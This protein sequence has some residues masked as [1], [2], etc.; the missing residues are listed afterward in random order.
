MKVVVLGGDGML[1]HQVAQRLSQSCEVVA[2]I[3]KPAASAQIAALRGCRVISGVEVRVADALQRLLLDERP[4]VVINTVGIVKQ[5]MAAVDPIESIEVNSLFPHRLAAMCKVGS[6]RLIHISTDCVFSGDRGNYQES[7]HPD[8][9]DLYGRTKLLGEVTG[10]GCLTI[11]TSIIGLE[12]AHYSGLI[13]WFLRQVKPV[14]GFRQAWWNGLTTFELARVSDT[15]VKRTDL[16][17][18]WHVSGEPITKYQLL[19]DLARLVSDSITVVP[20][21]TVVI[22]RSLNSERF[23]AALPYSPPAW[24]QM[25]Q[26]LAC[27]V[28]DRQSSRGA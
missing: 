21:D 19:V 2:T 11:R 6:A 26:E 15:L 12:L 10:D 8:P 5:R 25:L 14:R 17:G 20:D 22:D 9:V 7:D 18:L 16:V 23:R 27:A 24:E 1:G 28:R 13:E 4:E 3:R